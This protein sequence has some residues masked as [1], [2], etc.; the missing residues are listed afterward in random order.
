MSEDQQKPDLKHTLQK[1]VPSALRKERDT[2][3]RL[4]ERAGPI[5]ARLRLED[6]V[7][8][9]SS[10]TAKIKPGSR[11]FLFVCFGNIMRSPM[12]ELLLRK[13]VADANLPDI[14][15]SS[16]G[17]HAVPDNPAHPRAVTASAELGLPLAEHRAQLLTPEM[18]THADAIFAMD[19]QN[20][21]ELLALYPESAS[22]ILMLSVYAD[23]PERGREIA[24]PYFGDIDTTRRCYSVLQTC[25]RNLTA[26]L[27]AAD[28]NQA[29][30]ESN[31]A[32]P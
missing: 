3:L 24:D 8:I 25:V 18:V 17:L 14:R 11:S 21:A 12:A 30:R 26:A 4:G 2:F 13:S 29:S 27:V 15:V 9:R 5:Y 28:K 20:K 16:A 19:F 23:G 6:I 31:A 7:G 22:K 32:S 1:L 10:N